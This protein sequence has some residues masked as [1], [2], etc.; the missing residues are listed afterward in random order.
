MLFD[1]LVSRVEQVRKSKKIST[2]GIF[3][4]IVLVKCHSR[5]IAQRANFSLW[6]HSIRTPEGLHALPRTEE[7]SV[8][9]ERGAPLNS[10]RDLEANR[11]RCHVRTEFNFKFFFPSESIVTFQ[12]IHQGAEKSLG[13]K[14]DVFTY[15]AL[16]RCP[17][18]NL[19]AG[20]KKRNK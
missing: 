12:I 7:A 6:R 8:K 5:L 10:A 15:Y 4:P 1:R 14:F 3:V 19:K 9:L 2:F 18:H 11:I 20:R 17:E 13:K 16:F